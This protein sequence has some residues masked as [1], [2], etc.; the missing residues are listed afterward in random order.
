M[1]AT[2]ASSGDLIA[3][4]RYA[5]AVAARSD[6]DLAAAADLFAQ[7]AEAAPGWAAAWFTLGEVRVQLGEHQ[8]AIDA[9]GRALA[10]D[11]A[12]RLGAGLHLARLG[13]AEA[14]TAMTPAYVAALF[15]DFAPRFDTSL[16]DRL[17]YRGPE[18]IA[19]AVRAAC[20][21]TNRPFAFDRMVD[22]GCGTGL[23]AV[24]F[25]GAAAIIDGVDIAPRMVAAA[26]RR[27]LYR[28]LVA[29]DLAGWL[30]G[31]PPASADLAVAADVFVY[32]ADLSPVL[33][34]MARVLAPGGLAA[35][36]CE[37]HGGEGTVLLSGLR[38]AHG[39]AVVREAIAGASL[40]PRSIVPVSTRLEAGQPTQGLLAVAERPA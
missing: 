16:V 30:A 21:A 39:E 34:R 31:Q 24:P 26:R 6:G 28:D 1:T 22:L 20:A 13:A 36:T 18:L 2:L 3:D 35:F 33:A 17:A 14:A 11:P 10:A 29:G 32:I 9:F 7:A 27:G 5:W 19:A 25:A 4:R 15:D 8:A 12:D 40:V 38:Y 23:A 37:T